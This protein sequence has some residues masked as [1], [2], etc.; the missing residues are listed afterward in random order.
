MLGIKCVDGNHGLLGWQHCHLTLRELQHL[1]TWVGLIWPAVCW[2]VIH[3]FLICVACRFVVVVE[4]GLFA[5]CWHVKY[6]LSY[7]LKFCV[8]RVLILVLLMCP[9]LFYGLACSCAHESDNC[10]KCWDSASVYAVTASF[11]SVSL[12]TLNY[13]GGT[14][15]LSRLTLYIYIYITYRTANLQTLHFIY[16][17]NKYT[18]WIF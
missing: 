15:T 17:V 1:L 11:H 9:T 7:I 14:L 13:R 12:L 4:V 16:L 3:V 18:Y 5:F 8:R 2:K 10:L 6:S